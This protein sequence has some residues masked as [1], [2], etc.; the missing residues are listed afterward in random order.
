MINTSIFKSIL[1]LQPFFFYTCLKLLHSTV[2]PIHIHFLLHTSPVWLLP[3]TLHHFHP[4]FSPSSHL[5]RWRA[6]VRVRTSQER[7]NSSRGIS[8]T[9]SSSYRGSKAF[10]DSMVE[11]HSL[12]QAVSASRLA[13]RSLS[14]AHLPT[15][16]C[17]D[18]SPRLREFTTRPHVYIHKVMQML[19][20]GFFF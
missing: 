5:S 16:H 4:S 6:C 19:I 9:G 1:S 18:L 17:E 15:H 2:Y 3:T 8:E 11:K 10:S 12:C 13:Q 7:Y 14:A 20:L